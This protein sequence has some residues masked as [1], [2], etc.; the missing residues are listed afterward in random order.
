MGKWDEEKSPE[1]IKK[2]I[3]D[4]HTKDDTGTEKWKKLYEEA[5]GKFIKENPNHLKEILEDP[6]FRK[7]RS[8]STKPKRKSCSCKKK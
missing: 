8:K 6:E 4:M 5:M 3:S 2:Q 7:G 1:K